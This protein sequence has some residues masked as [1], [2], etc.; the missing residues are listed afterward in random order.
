MKGF[1]D[2]T[3]TH[4]TK[5]GPAGGAKGAAKVSQVMREFRSGELHSGSKTGPKVK[6]RKQAVAIALSEARRAPK[7][8]EGGRVEPM[9][10][11]L[12]RINGKLQ[13]PPPGYVSER[14]RKLAEDAKKVDRQR[15]RMDAMDSFTNRL[16]GGPKPGP[17]YAEGG[18]VEVVHK[19]ERVMH[20]GKPLTKLAHGGRAMVRDRGPLIKPGC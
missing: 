4:Y 16:V 3:R 19:H 8:A 11:E 20:P 5:G 13:E 1:K 12:V 17:K 18:A 2:S 6:S 10:K 9:P 14:D 15:R 7:Y